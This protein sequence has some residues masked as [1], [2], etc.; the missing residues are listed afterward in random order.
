MS[1]DHDDC[2]EAFKQIKEKVQAAGFP[3]HMQT[4]FCSARFSQKNSCSECESEQGCSRVYKVM[5]ALHELSK[6]NQS[7]MLKTPLDYMAAQ[8]AFEHGSEAVIKRGVVKD[9][10][11]KIPAPKFLEKEPNQ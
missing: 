1:C 4:P 9:R 6:I 7:G 2:R 3:V 5:E 11:G 8:L 10:V